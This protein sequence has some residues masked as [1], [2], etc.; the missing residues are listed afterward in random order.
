MEVT[1]VMKKKEVCKIAEKWDVDVSTGRSKRD[2]IRD[3]QIKEG[4]APGF[5]SKETCDNDCLWDT[6][7]LRK[8]Q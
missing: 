8:K 4:Y 1:E 5:K 6:D 7:C 2:I 3:I